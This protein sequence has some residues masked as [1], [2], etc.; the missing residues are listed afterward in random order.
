M[1]IITITCPECETI[2]AGNILESN[3]VVKCPRANC[4]TVLR[5]DSLPESDRQHILQNQEQYQI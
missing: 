1:R 3:R 5:F 2:V 4:N